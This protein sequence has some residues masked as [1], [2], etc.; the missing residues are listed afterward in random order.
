[1]LCSI[2]SIDIWNSS[3]NV[4]HSIVYI[5]LFY[6]I[7]VHTLDSITNLEHDGVT[8]RR[9]LETVN[10][11]SNYTIGYSIPTFL[12]VFHIFTLFQM[13]IYS[14]RVDFILWFWLVLTLIPWEK[15][16]LGLKTSVHGLLLSML[17]SFQMF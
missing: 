17:H 8:S 11:K 13:Y 6:Y 4:F 14:S 15:R 12:C 9:Q 10:V 7:K 16:I 3:Q 5:I 1:M 2:P